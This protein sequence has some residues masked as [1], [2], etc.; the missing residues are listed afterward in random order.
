MTTCHYIGRT[1][2]LWYLRAFIGPHLQDAR[3]CAVCVRMCLSLTCAVS[4]P[5]TVDPEENTSYPELAVAKLL[6]PV[7]QAPRC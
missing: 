2:V 7:L 1:A 3:I 5:L 4:L 6:H